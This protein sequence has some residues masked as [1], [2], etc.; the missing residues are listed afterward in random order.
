SNTE[1]ET[2]AAP[3]VELYTF[4]LFRDVTLVILLLAAA[5]ALFGSLLRSV[6]G[7][8]SVRFIEGQE[9]RGPVSLLNLF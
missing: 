5:L 2:S 9:E 1:P 7:V 6:F 4:R 8:P 3:S